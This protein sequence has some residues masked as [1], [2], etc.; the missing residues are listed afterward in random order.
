MF[1]INKN[2]NEIM[3]N[4]TRYEYI[5]NWKIR[6]A[7]F[8]MTCYKVCPKCGSVLSLD[9][10]GCSNCLLQFKGDKRKDVK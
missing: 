5:P 8:L 7:K 6:Q 3:L 9:A 2:Y 4:Q 10:K 1:N